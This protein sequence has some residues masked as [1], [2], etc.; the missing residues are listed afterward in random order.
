[1]PK[2]LEV[3]RSGEKLEDEVEGRDVDWRQYCG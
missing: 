1:M 2:Y 3:V